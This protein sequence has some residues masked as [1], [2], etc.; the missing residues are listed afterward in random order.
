[1]VLVSRWACAG[2]LVVVAIA[3]GGVG[4]VGAGTEGEVRRL[5]GV[6]AVGLPVAAGW[7]GVLL[8]PLPLLWRRWLRGP[9]LV[10]A[11][12]RRDGLRDC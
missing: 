1:M 3:G 11:R 6:K 10:L 9:G 8:L 12:E 2:G 4:G 5:G 7:R